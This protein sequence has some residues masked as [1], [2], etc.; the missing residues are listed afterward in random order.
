MLASF[1]MTARVVVRFFVRYPG[2]VAFIVLLAIPSVH[3]FSREIA[4][5]AEC[6][7]RCNKSF[8]DTSS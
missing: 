7:L 1:F 3:R 5:A 6:L 8:A 4:V 2:T